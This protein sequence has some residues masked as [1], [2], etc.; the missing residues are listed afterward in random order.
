[1]DYLYFVIFAFLSG[2]LGSMGLGG[3]GILILFLTL[4]A[5]VPQLKAQGINLMFFIP[6]ALLAT[7]I[8]TKRG[9]INF[10]EI[11]P[12]NIAGL[13]GRLLGIYIS[14]HL[15]ADF[16][17]KLFGLALII[18]GMREIFIKEKP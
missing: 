5:G 17:G 14:S 6:I 18:L 2:L 4:F 10:K 9:N 12:F 8:Y 7:I 3:G 16:L 1:M 15:E 13:P 11:L